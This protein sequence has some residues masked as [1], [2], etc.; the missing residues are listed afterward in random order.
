M[1]GARKRIVG[2]GERI[3]S[4]LDPGKDASGAVIAG[5]T[6]F[7]LAP[8]IVV[9]NV[10]GAAIVYAC[11][12]WIVPSPDL[13]DEDAVRVANLIALVAFLAFALPVGVIL[14]VRTFRIRAWLSEVV[15]VIAATAASSTSSRRPSWWAPDGRSPSA[16]AS[17]TR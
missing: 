13:A 15:D 8:A 6:G 11:A 1:S 16:G 5:R 4:V 12:A 2:A 14:G 3:A 10:I 17:A 9:A 7:L